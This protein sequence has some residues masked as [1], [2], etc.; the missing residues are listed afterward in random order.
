MKHHNLAPEQVDRLPAWFEVRYPTYSATWDEV[1]A[2][3]RQ[4]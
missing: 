1:V 4:G 2:E 3:R